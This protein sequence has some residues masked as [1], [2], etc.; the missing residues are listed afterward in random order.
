VTESEAEQGA[1]RNATELVMARDG[2]ET[3]DELTAQVVAADA[4]D[5][6]ARSPAA[7]AEPAMQSPAVKQLH[8]QRVVRWPPEQSLPMSTGAFAQHSLEANRTTGPAVDAARTFGLNAASMASVAYATVHVA[9]SAS[10]SLASDR[11]PPPAGNAKD[12]PVWSAMSQNMALFNKS[13]V[14]ACL[15]VSAPQHVFKLPSMGP[16][17][18]FLRLDDS[19]MNQD[20]TERQ[21]FVKGSV[22]HW[23]GSGKTLYGF[24]L[25]FQGPDRTCEF[26]LV[27]RSILENTIMLTTPEL[28]LS[29]KN[30]T[31]SRR[32]EQYNG[33]PLR[34]VSRHQTL[35]PLRTSLCERVFHRSS[36]WQ[37]EWGEALAWVEG[38]RGLQAIA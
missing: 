22:T 17:N 24:G 3:N 32:G 9:H 33:P 36:R 14:D 21:R 37:D 29:V 10:T 31:L 11:L 18:C 15:T 25:L 5:A 13:R 20:S 19:A 27:A 38:H 8:D 34:C 26:P 16:Q 23:N 1:A 4:A 7:A 6:A 12:G 2:M 28:V 35:C 30:A